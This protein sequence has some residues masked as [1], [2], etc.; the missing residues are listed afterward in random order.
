MKIKKASKKNCIVAMGVFDTAFIRKLNKDKDSTANIYIIEYD[1]GNIVFSKGVGMDT[2]S[3]VVCVTSNQIHL[4][5]LLYDDLEEI[6]CTIDL[7]REELIALAAYLLTKENTRKGK[8][9]Q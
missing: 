9:K 4:N 7:T 3:I 5:A 2:L 8:G 1:S 6:E